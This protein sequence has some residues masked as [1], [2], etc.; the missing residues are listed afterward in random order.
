[1]GILPE[2]Q[3]TNDSV[4]WHMHDTSLRFTWELSRFL[5][6]LHLSWLH[7]DKIATDKPILSYTPLYLI[8]SV[9]HVGNAWGALLHTTAWL[10]AHNAGSRSYQTPCSQLAV[11]FG[12]AAGM[13]EGKV[14]LFF[15]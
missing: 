6:S 8:A 12:R 2:Q 4:C 9:M 5:I 14:Q 15:G 1:M 13:V 3:L 11:G 10:Q 7:F